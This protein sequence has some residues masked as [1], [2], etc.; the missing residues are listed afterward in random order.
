MVKRLVEAKFDSLGL[1]A[2]TTGN[3]AEYLC[4]CGLDDRHQGAK[5]EGA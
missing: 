5:R 4:R 3:R 1:E 2:Q